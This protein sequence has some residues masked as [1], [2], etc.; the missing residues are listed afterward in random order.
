[1]CVCKICT[2]VGVGLSGDALTW[3]R[4]SCCFHKTDGA[5]A[6]C[7]PAHTH[8]TMT[9]LAIY[10]PASSNIWLCHSPHNPN[11]NNMWVFDDPTEGKVECLGMP[12]KPAK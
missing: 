7:W 11:I 6:A 1:M 12:A 9:S 5:P 2:C 8:T 4:G 3:V 10:V